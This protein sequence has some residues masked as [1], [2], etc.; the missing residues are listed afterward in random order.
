MR[1]WGTI[2]KDESQEPLSGTALPWNCNRSSQ[3]SSC[4]VID[5]L[6]AAASAKCKHLVLGV[7]GPMKLVPR[8]QHIGLCGKFW[9]E[10]IKAEKHLHP[11]KWYHVHGFRPVGN[12]LVVPALRTQAMT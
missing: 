7:K 3:P 12:G 6:V 5:E 10:E 8:R 1:A 2:S 11:T 4:T 9:H